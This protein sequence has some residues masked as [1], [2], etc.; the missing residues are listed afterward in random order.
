ML[1]LLMKMQLIFLVWTA[2]GATG[3]I[4]FNLCLG[5]TDKKSV[6]D[7]VRDTGYKRGAYHPE[8]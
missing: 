7:F 8:A 5:D 3:Q 1:V 6:S 4:G 2:A